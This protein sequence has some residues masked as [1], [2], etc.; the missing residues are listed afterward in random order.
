MMSDQDEHIKI[1]KQRYAKGEITKKQYMEIKEDL[2]EE[3]ESIPYS[4]RYNSGGHGLRNLIVLIII[5]GIIFFLYQIAQAEAFRNVQIT[6]SGAS[7]GNVGLT[8]ADLNL[9]LNFYN[10][11]SIPATLSSISYS[12]YANNNYLG[13]GSINGPISIA[14][15]NTATEPTTVTISYLGAVQ[16]VWAT[17]TSGQVQLTVSGDAVINT[18]LGPITIPFNQSIYSSNSSL[19]V[20]STSY[21]TTQSTQYTSYYTTSIPTTTAYYGSQCLPQ[22]GYTCSNPFLSS[23]SGELNVTLGENTG[24]NWYDVGLVWVPSGTDLSNVQN[25]FNSPTARFYNYMYSGST[26]YFLL[27]VTGQGAGPGTIYNGTIWA[28]Y[29]VSPGGGTYYTEIASA[30][31]TATP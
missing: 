12:V 25:L 13:S 21:P 9:D 11:L 18:I 30:Y 27:P 28:Q 2:K 7:M 22:S 16:S 3:K 26:Y 31:L 10:P 14:P 6:L 15:H 23:Y 29:S 19:S 24:N 4:K 5:L 1:L 8:S 17:L 20:S